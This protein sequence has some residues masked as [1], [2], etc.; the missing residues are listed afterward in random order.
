MNLIDPEISYSIIKEIDHFKLIFSSSY[1]AK[2]VFIEINQ[3][4]KLSDNYFDLIPGKDKEITFFHKTKSEEV[5][6][7]KVF[8]LWD[9][10]NNK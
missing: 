8:S 9:I 7:L 3:D 1:M 10:N 5:P 6:V 4:G 2:N